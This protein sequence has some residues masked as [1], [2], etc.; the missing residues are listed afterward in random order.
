LNFQVAGPDGD[1]FGLIAN[2]G[3]Y[4][5]SNAWCCVESTRVFLGFSIGHPGWG[6]CVIDLKA[7]NNLVAHLLHFWDN[8]TMSCTLRLVSQLL[9]SEDGPAAVEYAVLMGMIIVVL[10]SVVS[11]LAQ[12]ISGTFSTVNSTLGS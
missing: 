6:T 4:R 7:R 2:P 11:S 3:D 9:V 12:S 8:N 1:K 10:V 5:R